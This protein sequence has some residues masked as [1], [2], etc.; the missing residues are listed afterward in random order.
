MKKTVIFLVMFAAI[1]VISSCKGMEKCP[2]Y[3]EQDSVE[4]AESD[5]A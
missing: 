3:S 4:T 1:I 2:A 5:N